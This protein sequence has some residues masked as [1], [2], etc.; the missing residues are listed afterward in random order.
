MFRYRRKRR[1]NNCGSGHRNLS[2][3]VVDVNVNLY[4]HFCQV[5]FS[6]YGPEPKGE[7]EEPGTTTGAEPRIAAEVVAGRYRGPG[8]TWGGRHNDSP[9]RPARRSDAGVD[10]PP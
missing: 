4:L 1:I 5:Q 10:L 7:K 9:H 6:A 2:F 8:A 3:R